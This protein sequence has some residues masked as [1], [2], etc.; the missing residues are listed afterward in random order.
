SPVQTMRRSLDRNIERQSNLLT[1]D[2][3]FHMA[4]DINRAI[5]DLVS[6]I[7]EPQTTTSSNYYQQIITS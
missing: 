7:T 1:I 4:D 6:V 2:N 3:L 5:G